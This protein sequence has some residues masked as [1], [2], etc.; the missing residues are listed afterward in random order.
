MH[1]YL[2]SEVSSLPE[3]CKVLVLLAVLQAAQYG[4]PHM[5]ELARSVARK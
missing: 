5:P 1:M 2:S 4:G 3:L